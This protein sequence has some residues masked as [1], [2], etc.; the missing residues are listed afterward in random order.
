MNNKSKK[1]QLHHLTEYTDSAILEEIRRVATLVGSDSLT[2]RDFEKH[3]RVGISTIRRHFGTWRQALKSAGL[4][5]LYND[6][7][8]ITEKMKFQ[9]G[10]GMSDNELLNMIQ[11]VASKLST[12]TLTI[13]E[14]NQHAPISAATAC[15]RFGGW[16]KALKQ[17]GLI[18]KNIQKRYTDEECFEN[19]LEVWTH[20]GRPP[21]Y[22]EMPLPPSMISVRA[23]I[24]RWGSWRKALQAFVDYVNADEAL[25]QQ[26]KPK[27]STINPTQRQESKV[28]EKPLT[29]ANRR[30]IKI[31]LRYKILKRDCFRCVR[32]GRSPATCIGLELH[33]DHIKPWSKGGLTV[34]ENLRTLCRDCNIG[35]GSETE[36]NEHT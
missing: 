34:P 35:K 28:I 16:C 15:R 24:G 32:C 17:A 20:Y 2:I 1:F 23:Y 18:P 7:K 4:E 26:E 33:I 5:H 9:R 29:D 36:E 22:Q 21:K 13:D 25:E 3:S 19:L 14:F 31:G 8:S 27:Y 6:T 10:K 12:D 30:E 11:A